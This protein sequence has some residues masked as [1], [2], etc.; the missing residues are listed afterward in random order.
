MKEVISLAMACCYSGIG[1]QASNELRFYSMQ[2]F[3]AEFL[4]LRVIIV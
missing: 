1:F 3:S 2:M 4:I